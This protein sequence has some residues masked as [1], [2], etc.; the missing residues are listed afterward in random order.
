MIQPNDPRLDQYA[1]VAASKIEQLCTRW[2]IGMEV[3]QDVVKLALFDIVLY[4]GELSIS[5]LQ[6]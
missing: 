5:I 2:R 1:A 6:N 4:I 3:G